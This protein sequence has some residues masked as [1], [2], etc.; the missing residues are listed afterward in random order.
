MFVPSSLEEA[1]AGLSAHPE[2]TLLA[3]GTDLMVEVNEAQ[4]E[5]RE[6]LQT[7]GR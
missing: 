5:A 4:R 2:A 6:G 3:G 1:L 7:K